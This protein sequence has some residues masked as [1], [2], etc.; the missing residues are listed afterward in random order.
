MSEPRA[1][2]HH[3]GMRRPARRDGVGRP[4]SADEA[5]FPGCRPVPMDAAQVRMEDGPRIE[6]WDGKRGVAWMVR[7]P[8]SAVHER[9][10]HRLAAL[11]DRIGEARGAAIECC[12]ATTF[13][14]RDADGKHVRA[15]EADQTVYLDASQGQALRHPASVLG[16]EAP[17]DVVLEVDHTTDVR[18]RK[19][20]EYERWRFPEVWVEVPEAE[21][22]GR[23]RR[24]PGLTIHMLCAKSGRY[25]VATAS[26]ALPG[27]T[28]DE[29]HR[30]LNEPARSANTW[31]A[32]QR[33]GRALG[34][35][36]GTERADAPNH[37]GGPVEARAAAVRVARA[38]GKAEATVA[39]VQQI[40]SQ[41]GIACSPGFL[42][43][44]LPRSVA[45]YTPSQLVAA[46]FACRNEAEF[47][48]ALAAET[49]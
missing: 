1:T 35:R 4:S 24:P 33:V 44:P 21:R 37:R 22:Q 41:R 18:R 27:W 29:I 11:L 3:A 40:L 15:M 32:L 25:D 26:R 30:A 16:S 10:V 42:A 47:L 43:G 12:G 9:P 7:E 14:E 48:D 23:S 36:E 13:Y 31:A 20:H 8:A 39:A 46:A 2:Y 28:A 38:E 17:P 45:A 19:L 34:Q 5:G 49:R 6:Y